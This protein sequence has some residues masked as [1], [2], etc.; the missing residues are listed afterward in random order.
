MPT[1]TST[2][3]NP[4]ETLTLSPDGGSLG[5][6]EIIG[7]VVGVLGFFATAAGT[8]YAYK[9]TKKRRSRSSLE[10]RDGPLFGNI[11]LSS[12]SA[13]NWG[14]YGRRPLY[15]TNWAGQQRLYSNSGQRNLMYT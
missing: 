1:S 12:N 3:Q 5:V 2:S 15:G 10:S 11:E 14:G 6:S 13:T 4:A 8:Y 9:A 7:I